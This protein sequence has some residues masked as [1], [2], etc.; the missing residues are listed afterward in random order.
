ML[1]FPLPFAAALSACIAALILPAGVGAAAPR[2][3]QFPAGGPEIW[4]NS[5]PLQVEALRG[6]VVLVDVWTFECW[7]C[8]R[9]FPWLRKLEAALAGES[10]T[11]IGVH[12]PEFERER[13]PGRV[14][15]KAREFGLTH[16][17]LIDN[18]HAYWRALDNRFWPAF[19]L[20]DKLGVIRARYVGETHSGDPQARAIEAEIRKLLNEPYP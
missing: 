10:F 16:P 3:P 14:L 4:L 5:P 20:V 7:N 12:S 9:S 6:K 11:V 17:V 19:H 1:R 15:E 18:D 2:L 8:Y 13:D